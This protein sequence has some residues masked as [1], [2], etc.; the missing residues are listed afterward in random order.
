MARPRG[1]ENRIKVK[2]AHMV[3]LQVAFIWQN[4]K[5]ILKEQ[6]KDSEVINFQQAGSKGQGIERLSPEILWVLLF[7][8]VTL[9]GR[10]QGQEE[11]K[12]QSLFVAE[13][14]V[15]HLQW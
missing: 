6:S 4:S 15:L 2:T 3:P 10:Q 14:R 7:S 13:K 11:G 12:E 9:E 5:G 8:S 1:G